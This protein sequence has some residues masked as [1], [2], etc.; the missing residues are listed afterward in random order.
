MYVCTYALKRGINLF[1]C[2]LICNLCGKDINIL[3]A[4]GF[5]DEQL[6]LKEVMRTAVPIF[7]GELRRTRIK[8]LLLAL[9]ATEY[10]YFAMLLDAIGTRRY[11]S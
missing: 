5:F 7:N 9:L 2:S 1:V 8:L 4:L 3:C 11:L 10:V 6:C